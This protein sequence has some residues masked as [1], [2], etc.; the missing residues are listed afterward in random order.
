MFES[1]RLST[2]EKALRVN[3]DRTIYGSFNE[4]GAGQEV[5][6]NFFRAG[7]SSGTIASSRSAYDMKVSDTIYGKCRRYVCEERLMTMLDTE[8]NAIQELLPERAEKTRFFSYANTVE[9]LNYHKTNQGHGWIG[10]RFQLS[11]ESEPNDIVMHVKMHDERSTWQQEALGILGVNLVY[12][13]YYFH[14]DPDQLLNSLADRLSRERIECDMIRISG[15]D[16]GHVDNRL[17]ALKLVRKGMTDATMFAPDGNVLQ[18]TEALYK[19]NVLLLRGRFRP[20]TLV[21]F[22]MLNTGYS[23]FAKEEDVD[24]E[25]TV[26][27][28]ELTMKDLKTGGEI[29]EQDFLDRAELL[30]MLGQT[31]MISNYVKYYKVVE[32][33]S[34]LTRN[35]KIGVILGIYNLETIF[36]ERY[37][38]NLP[39]GILQAFGMGFGPNM[40]LY[41]YP[42]IKLNR[43]EEI[44]Q[45]ENLDIPDNLKGLYDHMQSNNKMESITGANT[46]LLHIYSDRVIE[47]IKE[48][49]EGWDEMVPDIVAKTIIDHALFGYQEPVK[50]KARIS[51]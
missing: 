14:D 46:D 36:D 9:A 13:A 19:K 20:P 23:Q 43:A 49:Q 50:K 31:V 15:P 45:I 7:G 10:L 3:L 26:T 48:G 30:G 32:Y 27:L 25:R 17:L 51:N 16:F 37:Y 22:D 21:N 29:D 42:A 2:E 1:K 4:I 28:F 38:D 5:S 33:L 18:P 41:V 24:E 34:D 11:P 6:T 35:R 40:K 39:G 12:A 44:Y 8:F 47:M